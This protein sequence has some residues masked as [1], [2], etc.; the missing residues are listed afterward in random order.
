MNDWHEIA[1]E[2]AKMLLFFA[3][4]LFG[5]LSLVALFYMG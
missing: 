3:A 1:A 4:V 2:A 5:S